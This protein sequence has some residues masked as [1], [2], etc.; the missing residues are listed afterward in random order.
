MRWNLS[1]LNPYNPRSTSILLLLLVLLP[2]EVM[3]QDDY[4]NGPL[5]TETAWITTDRQ[6]YLPGENISF[7]AIVLES[8][9]WVPSSLSCV[10]RVELL[11][12]AG[13]SVSHGEYLL[14]E[15]RTSNRIAVPPGTTSGWYYLRAYTNW[16]RNRPDLTQSYLPLKIV[17]PAMIGSEP[18]ATDNN[19]I[20][21]LTPENGRLSPGINRCA[22]FSSLLRIRP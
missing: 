6:I 18:L 14:E 1:I 9:N 8:D 4:F 13:N 16:M 19:M 2:L 10:L 22:L 3:S 12:S 21:T 17:N 20:I 7:T 11:D 5:F 15:S